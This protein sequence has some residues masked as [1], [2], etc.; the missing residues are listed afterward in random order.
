MQRLTQE[1][2]ERLVKH[3]NFLEEELKDYA[4]FK[5]ITREEYFKDRDKRRNVERWIENI[6][7]SIVDVS[8]II[9]T[10]EGG[11]IPDTYRGIVSMISTV[12]GLEEVDAEKLSRWVRFRNIVAHE[13]LDIK[14]SS[15]NKFINTTDSLYKDA[16]KIFKKYLKSKIESEGSDQQDH[17]DIS[18]T[19]RST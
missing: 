19:S 3:L 2:K 5:K 7:N 17:Q 12:E 11:I 10:F 1:F 13:Y 14:W 18:P 6:I 4:Q 9:L 15:I 8:K 16:L